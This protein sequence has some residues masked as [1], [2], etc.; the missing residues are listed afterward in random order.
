MCCSGSALVRGEFSKTC[1]PPDGDV[2]PY[3]SDPNIIIKDCEPA[4]PYVRVGTGART[5]K[6]GVREQKRRP[7]GRRKALGGRSEALDAAFQE[8]HQR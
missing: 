2:I 1:T 5:G 8:P 3:S 7:S 6:E 4:L